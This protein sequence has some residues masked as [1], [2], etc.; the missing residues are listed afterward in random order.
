MK[1]IITVFLVF[2]LSMPSAVSARADKYTTYTDESILYAVVNE[3]TF[4]EFFGVSPDGLNASHEMYS[5]EDPDERFWDSL[6]NKIYI[7][8]SASVTYTFDIDGRGNLPSVMTGKYITIKNIY[9]SDERMMFYCG[10]AEETAYINGR[11]LVFYILINYSPDKRA[12]SANISVYD[13]EKPDSFTHFTIGEPFLSW[14][15]I[16]AWNEYDH[17]DERGLYN[18]DD[19]YSLIE[20]TNAMFEKEVFEDEVAHGLEISYNPARNMLKTQVTTNARAI[21]EHF[22]KTGIS[23]TEVSEI[24]VT[25]EADETMFPRIHNI[26]SYYEEVGGLEISHGTNEFRWY[27]VLPM[28]WEDLFGYFGENAKHRYI[29]EPGDIRRTDTLILKDSHSVDFDDEPYEPEYHLY[30][31]FLT[32]GRFR[33]SSHVIYTTYYCPYG[34]D[35]PVCYITD[36]GTAETQWAELYVR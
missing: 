14:D 17:S 22:S 8:D 4:I 5:E 10:T 21:D 6:Y 33:V 27:Y 35:T 29:T 30:S 1:R 19:D 7:N 9:F 24:S 20:S 12:M 3:D 16:S 25:V 36:G 15:M 18:P 13:A 31:P 34:Y 2:L 32:K 26:H 28:F 23:K 11:N